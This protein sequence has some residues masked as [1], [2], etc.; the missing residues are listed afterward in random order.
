MAEMKWTN[1]ERLDVFGV[2]LI[3]WPKGIPQQNPSTL[4]SSQNRQLLAAL[5]KGSMKFERLYDDPS[6]EVSDKAK[7]QTPGDKQNEEDDFSWAYDS[8]AARSSQSTPLPQESQASQ[9][10]STS[11][12]PAAPSNLK[13]VPLP[14]LA[15]SPIISDTEDTSW[16]IETPQMDIDSGLGTYNVD[17]GWDEFSDHLLSTIGTD[18]DNESPI[19][20]PKKRPRTEAETDVGTGDS[21][22]GQGDGS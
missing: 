12:V 7:S 10:T 2:R 11:Q 20:R 21:N 17:F 19:L 1:P 18:W 22:P 14:P 4:K 13:R 8:E 3:G 15:S 16:R 5:Q 9:S 6:E